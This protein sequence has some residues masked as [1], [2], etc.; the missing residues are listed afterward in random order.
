LAFLLKTAVS[1]HEKTVFEYTGNISPFR[2]ERYN[3]N[4]GYKNAQVFW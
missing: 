3:E 2:E 4:N 1:N